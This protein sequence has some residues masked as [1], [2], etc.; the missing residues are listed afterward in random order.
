M[1]STS[2]SSITP[3]LKRSKTFSVVERRR[4]SSSADADVNT[5]ELASA[6][7]LAAAAAILASVSVPSSPDSSILSSMALSFLALERDL[8]FMVPLVS[9]I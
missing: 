5:D 3:S 2:S 4:C 6:L 1:R 8:S 7:A 9:A